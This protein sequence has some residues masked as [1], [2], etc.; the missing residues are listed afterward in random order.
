VDAQELITQCSQ[1]SATHDLPDEVG[2]VSERALTYAL[3]PMLVMH[4]RG[5]MDQICADFW[6]QILRADDP[7]KLVVSV[8]RAAPGRLSRFCLMNSYPCLSPEILNGGGN[9][10]LTLVTT[11]EAEFDRCGI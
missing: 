10:D 11:V 8:N 1:G 3:R 5:G 4:S 9:L 6:A 7:A 2:S